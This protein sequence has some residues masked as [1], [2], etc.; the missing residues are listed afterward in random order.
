MTIVS[1]I[2]AKNQTTVPS[3]LRAV[4]GVGPGDHLRYDIEPDG[5]VVVAKADMSFDSLIGLLKGE[6]RLTGE[7]LGQAIEDAREAMAL[8]H[9]WP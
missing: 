4:L 6:V 5:R 8:G 2:T 7:E 9:D 1:K 3:D